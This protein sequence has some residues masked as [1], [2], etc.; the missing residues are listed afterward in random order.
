MQY[1]FMLKLFPFSLKGDAKSWF[2]NLTP[3]SINSPQEIVRVFN[4]KYFP[5]HMK[6]A[7]LQDIYNFNQLEEGYLPQAWGRFCALL[8]ACPD[9][10]IKKNELLDIFYN[11]LTTESRTYLDSCAGCVFRERM[12]EQG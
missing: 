8:K 3:G 9:H 12:V 11:G 1:Y 10:P 4:E 7:V 5:T 2:N 6:Q